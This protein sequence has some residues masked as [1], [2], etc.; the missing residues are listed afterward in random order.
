M[1]PSDNLFYI[2][3]IFLIFPKNVKNE[4]RLCPLPY[5]ELPNFWRQSLRPFGQKNV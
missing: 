4:D 1:A 3:A 5:E 2:C